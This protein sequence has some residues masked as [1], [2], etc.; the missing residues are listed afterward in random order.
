MAVL[1]RR[2]QC[3]LCGSQRLTRDFEKAYDFQASE[4]LFGGRGQSVWDKGLPLTREEA[5]MVRVKLR[6]L[7]ADLDTVLDQE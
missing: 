7:L 4:N 3:A 2:I 6:A 5:E 1:L